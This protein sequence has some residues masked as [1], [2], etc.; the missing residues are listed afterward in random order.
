MLTCRDVAEEA[1]AYLDAGLPLPRR[2]G[3]RMHLAICTNCRRYMQQMRQTIS[4]LRALPSPAE[5]GTEAM[6]A[7]MLAML[8]PG[9]AG[10]S[11]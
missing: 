4:M 3:F 6:E 10:R 2:V 9:T 1:S 5:A 8:H 7:R 11:G